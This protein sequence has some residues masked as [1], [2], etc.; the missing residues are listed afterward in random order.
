MTR[1]IPSVVAGL[2]LLVSVWNAWS[3]SAVSARLDA[4]ETSGSDGAAAVEAGR[5]NA[6]RFGGR[7]EEPV[8]RV[9][10]ERAAAQA[11]LDVAQVDFDDPEIRGRLMDV[12]HEEREREGEER[13]AQFRD[14]MLA[15]VEAFAAEEGLDDG[16]T[17]RL[18]AEMERRMQAFGDM[19][20]AVRSGEI[21]MFD[22]RR[23]MMAQREAGR[24]AMVDLLGEDA[25]EALEERLF[26]GGPPGGGPRG[27]GPPPPF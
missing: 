6:R 18:M 11:G 22:A 14:A 12:L 15:E 7:A 4:L 3:L 21:S 5:A 27:G 25:A 16:T 13:R 26:G 23:D 24:E 17:D 10:L 2:A 1:A 9:A 8:G 20:R 19:R